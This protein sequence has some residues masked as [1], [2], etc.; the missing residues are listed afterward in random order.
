MF[1]EKHIP[2]KL[3]GEQLI[4]YVRPHW[5]YLL[6]SLFLSFVIFLLPIGLYLLI[7][8]TIPQILI[9]DITYIIFVLLGC[10]YYLMALLIFYNRFI[11]YHLDL[12]VVTNFRI[13]AIEQ[14]NIF[15]RT[16]SEHKIEMIQDVSANQ[17][18]LFQTMFNY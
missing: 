8:G 2:N 5:I 17:K 11:D 10:V 9:I 7:I 4:T 18:G 6:K 15:H 16:T 1:Q 12:W 3:P 13:I 14:N